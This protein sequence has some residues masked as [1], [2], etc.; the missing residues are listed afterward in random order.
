MESTISIILR[1]KN[2]E[3]W[4]PYCLDMI[5]RQTYQ[6][7]EII[8]VDNNSSDRTLKIAKDYKVTIRC[9]PNGDEFT[10]EGKCILS[11]KP[12][13]RRVVFSKAY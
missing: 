1:S 8:L 5:K 7:Y 10:E 3:K 2:E 6:D 12:S 9:I 11:G 13:S 4:L